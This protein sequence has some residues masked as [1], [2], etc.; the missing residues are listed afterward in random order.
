M[1]C[2]QLGQEP[3]PAR[4]PLEPSDFPVEVQMAFF[5]HSLLSDVWEGST[6]SYMGKDF[7]IL[8]YLFKLH[9]IDNPRAI[10]YFI[11]IYDNIIIEY[12]GQKNKDK[13]K[14]S[15]RKSSGGGKTY[16]HNVKG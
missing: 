1:I 14:A 8:E 9:D 6:G 7:S 3:D 5:M 4:M 11:K 12:I 13:Q 10:F 15:E 16:T 2:E